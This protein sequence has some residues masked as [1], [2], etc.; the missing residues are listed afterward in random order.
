MELADYLE[1]GPKDAAE[2]AQLVGTNPD[3]LYRLLR[4][5][6]S[7]GV[8]TEVIRFFA[9]RK[10]LFTLLHSDG[11]IF[12]VPVVRCGGE[13]EYDYLKEPIEDTP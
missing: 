5:L 2:L 3:S 1:S 12:A 9:F 7:V 10:Q 13:T 8:F 4:A 6:A 11:G